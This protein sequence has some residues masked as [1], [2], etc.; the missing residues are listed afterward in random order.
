MQ[1][2]ITHSFLFQ[3]EASRTG[4]PVHKFQKINKRIIPSK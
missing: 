1:T 2:H 4:I 3:S